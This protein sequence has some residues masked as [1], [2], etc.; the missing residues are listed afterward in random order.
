MPNN[1]GGNFTSKELTNDVR[2]N[3]AR[4]A[5]FY[6]GCYEDF[7]ASGMEFRMTYSEYKKRWAKAK[8][9]ANRKKK[10]ASKQT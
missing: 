6:E 1:S 8:R 7:K 10:N 2:S 3:R 5:K 4:L 9:K